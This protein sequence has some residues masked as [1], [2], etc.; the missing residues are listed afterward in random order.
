MYLADFFP[1]YRGYK[2]ST[3]IYIPFVKDPKLREEE[4][5]DTNY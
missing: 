1:E 3:H 5:K 4:P 2:K